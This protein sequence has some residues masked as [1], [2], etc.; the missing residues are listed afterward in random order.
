MASSP[1]E[2]VEEPPAFFWLGLVRFFVLIY[3]VSHSY[4]EPDYD[5]LSAIRA[6]MS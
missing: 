4:S 2:T 1:E 3:G 5:L 6:W